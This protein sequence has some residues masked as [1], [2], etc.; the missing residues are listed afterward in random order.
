MTN[1]VEEKPISANCFTDNIFFDF[2]IKVSKMSQSEFS[3]WKKETL[4]KISSVVKRIRSESKPYR[5]KLY[6]VNKQIKS[7]EFESMI[8]DLIKETFILA[9]KINNIQ[10]GLS[11]ILKLPLKVNDLEEQHKKSMVARSVKKLKKSL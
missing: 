8:D 9:N 7:G 1:A 3:L 11:D 4:R 6:L 5:I 2:N 10:N